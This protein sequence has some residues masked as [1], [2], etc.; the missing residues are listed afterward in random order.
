MMAAEPEGHVL[1]TNIVVAACGLVQSGRAETSA[2]SCSMV[3]KH[4]LFKMS[5]NPAVRLKTW[6][7]RLGA[8]PCLTWRNK[9]SRFA[10]RRHRRSTPMKTY[11]IRADMREVQGAVHCWART[12]TS[13]LAAARSPLSRKIV[14]RDKNVRHWPAFK[15]L[16]SS[17]DRQ[18]EFRPGHKHR[19]REHEGFSSV[20]RPGVR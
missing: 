15:T 20:P 11:R 10:N 3:K 9:G 5:P 14:A 1:L 13:S 6:W 19:G 8:H 18:T 16:S 12:R 4:S 17:C 7:K 2:S